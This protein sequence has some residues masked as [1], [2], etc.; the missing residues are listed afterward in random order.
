MAGERGIVEEWGRWAGPGLAPYCPWGLAD[1]VLP[2]SI[3][4]PEWKGG[5]RRKSGSISD[6]LFFWSYHSNACGFLLA[7]ASVRPLSSEIDPTLFSALCTR[8]GRESPGEF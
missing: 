6:R 7:D 2:G 3:N 1:V 8:T 5:I 4:H